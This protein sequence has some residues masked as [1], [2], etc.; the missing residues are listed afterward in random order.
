MKELPII[1]SDL[2]SASIVLYVWI[3][4]YTNPA[5]EPKAVRMFRNIGITLF[6]TLI[7]DHLW[8]YFYET[9]DMSEASRRLLN[10]TASIEFLCIPVTFFFLLMYHRDKW[11][12]AD[13]IALAAD[14]GLFVVNI[15]NI[16]VPVY[17]DMDKNLYMVNAPGAKWI[18]P[19][20][21]ILLSFILTHDFLMTHDID[22]ENR[23]MIIF[24]ALIAALGAASCYLDGDVVAVWECFSIVYLLLYMALM[25]VFDKTDQVTGMPNRNAFTLAFSAEKETLC[26]F[27]SPL[28]L[29]T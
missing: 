22:L 23:I 15:M 12:M 9:S 18:Y 5:L 8:E 29:I 24:T 11:D 3:R 21:I 13:S 28:T 19:A 4:I 16:W 7:V 20:T 2:I 1:Y 6:S 10:T 17:S 27:L 14:A 26:P 25:R